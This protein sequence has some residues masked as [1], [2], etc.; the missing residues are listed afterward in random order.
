MRF[1][2]LELVLSEIHSE[3][4]PDASKEAVVHDE[5][6]QPVD[7]DLDL[8]VPRPKIVF[9]LRHLRRDPTYDRNARSSDR[10]DVNCHRHRLADPRLEKRA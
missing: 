3:G 1:K 4:A 8:S 5:R 9:E 2:L 10:L 7:I 6:G